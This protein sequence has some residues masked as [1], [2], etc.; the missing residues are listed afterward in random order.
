MFLSRQEARNHGKSL[1]AAQALDHADWK[2]PPAFH[3]EGSARLLPKP[4]QPVSE[5]ILAV[6]LVTRGVRVF[7]QKLRDFGLELSPVADQFDVSVRVVPGEDVRFLSPVGCDLFRFFFNLPRAM[8]L[9]SLEHGLFH[10]QG[11]NGF[12]RRGLAQEFRHMLEHVV[13]GFEQRPAILFAFCPFNLLFPGNR[14]DHFRQH[15]YD[16][17]QFF[18]AKARHCVKRL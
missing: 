16:I 1:V 17:R 6:R 15:V 12:A 4:A 2:F 9:E 10:L 14:L 18:Q 8:D 13:H 3:R 11:N 7:F 5:R